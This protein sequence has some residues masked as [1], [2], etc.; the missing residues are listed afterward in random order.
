MNDN[1][2]KITQK[3][4]Q[5]ESVTPSDN[6]A[7]DY[8][9]SLLEPLGFKCHK[10]IG[11]TNGHKDIL[12]FYAKLDNG[13][14]NF[15]FAGHTDVVPP[16]LNW[17]FPPFEA[18]ID[19]DILYGRGSSDMKAA[20]TCYIDALQTYLKT[21]NPRNS[22]SFIIT[23][24]EEGIAINGTKKIIEW[25]ENSNEKIDFCIV[26][27][28]TSVDKIGDTIKIGRRG[29]INFTLKINATQ[30]H[31]A[32]PEKAENPNSII[33]NILHLLN[34]YNFDNGN[35]KF[36]PSNLEIT[37]I[38][39]NNPTSNLIPASA[40]A[41]FNIRF[42]NEYDSNKLIS[43]I[44]S[45]IKEQYENFELNYRVSGESFLCDITKYTNIVCDAIKHKTNI[46][47]DISTSG[48]TSDARFLKSITNLCEFGLLNKTAH[49]VN[50]NVSIENLTKMRDI[51]LE[52][53]TNLDN[54]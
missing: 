2:V 14:N 20:I 17:D 1:L 4:I 9:I 15:A 41:N 51:Y 46:E 30:G 24:D 44:K 32:Y 28:P 18:I 29:S 50:E 45:L 13:G 49:K 12:N 31:V 39:V 43:L 19:N 37:S 47:T 34:H 5:F 11:K 27:E 3:L 40:T 10:I 54:S 33:V 21:N 8:L 7:I 16:G 36:L 35:E 26:G 38:D 53:I 23:G 48:G 22:F 52:I 42:N 6:G 25:L